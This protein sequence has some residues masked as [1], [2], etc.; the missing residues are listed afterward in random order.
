M[1]MRYCPFALSV[2]LKVVSRRIEET[3]TELFEERRPEGREKLL[4]P[5]R[6]DHFGEA[7]VCKP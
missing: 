6:D 1:Q 3:E 7:L 4:V 5:V 2:R